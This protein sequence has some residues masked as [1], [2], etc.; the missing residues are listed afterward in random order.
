MSDSIAL[1]QRLYLANYC[2]RAFCCLPASPLGEITQ[3]VSQM[4]CPTESQ[5]D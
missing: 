2:S 1:A 5:S 3:A 4:Q